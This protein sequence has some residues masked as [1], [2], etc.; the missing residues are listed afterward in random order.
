MILE[1]I[2]TTISAAGELN[3]APM[4]PLLHG[5]L[6]EGFLLR[7]FQTSTTFANLRHHRTG[8]LHVT[9]DALLLAQAAVGAIDPTPETFPAHKITGRVLAT[10]C[11]WVE[12]EVTGLDDSQPRTRLQCEVIH[13]GHLRE[14][15]G[16]NRAKHAIV[17]AAILATRVHML[18]REEILA[19]YEKFAVIVGKTGGEEEH[20]ALEL[21]R[22]Y[23]VG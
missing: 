3:I 9:D 16:F 18:D 14:H 15:F 4:G 21:L 10:A 6:E 19:E 13:S 5:P 2:V 17:E 7:P 22:E 12:F 23:V 8:V 20:R 1:A 11:R